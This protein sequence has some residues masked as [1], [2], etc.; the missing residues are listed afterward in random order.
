MVFT[1]AGRFSKAP[2]IYANLHISRGCFCRIKI[3]VEQNITILRPQGNF[4]VLN[5]NL[6][7]NSKY[8]ER[9]M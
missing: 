8:T 2:C 5:L 3:N 7:T 1:G 9:G 4:F 6:V